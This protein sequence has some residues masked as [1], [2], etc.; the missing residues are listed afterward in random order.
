MI[1]KHMKRYIGVTYEITFLNQLRRKTLEGTK[2]NPD[3]KENP[4]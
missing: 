1:K 3:M 2:K 4:C